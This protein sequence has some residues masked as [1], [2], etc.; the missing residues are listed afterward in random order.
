[1]IV[2][3]NLDNFKEQS[4]NDLT[5]VPTMGA[6]HDGHL[7]LIN[8]AKSI[9]ENVLVSI[10]VNPIQ[11]APNE[12]F[13]A[14][15]RDL[16][17]DFEKLE[18]LNVDY[19]LTP[20][21]DEIYLGSNRLEL[22]LPDFKYSFC[23]KSRPH[24]FDGV[25]NVLI[26]FF[27]IIRPKN[28]VMGLKDYQQFKLTEYMLHNLHLPI[29]LIGCET[30]RNENGLARSSRNKYLS[31]SELEEAQSIYKALKHVKVLFNENKVITID[32]IRNEFLGS[33]SKLICIDYLD[34]FDD[35][36]FTEKASSFQKKDRLLFAGHLGKTRLIDNIAL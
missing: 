9:S 3:D 10:F 20:Q 22:V 1:M 7:E 30:V 18:S 35:K 6:L 28:V 21:A 23:G 27:N 34:V 25:V 11:F 33:L 8:H 26:R 2:F 13:T 17:A 16:D 4:I 19:V 32:Q 29:N 15:P 31:E 5:F 24:F 36:L 14:Y 12:D